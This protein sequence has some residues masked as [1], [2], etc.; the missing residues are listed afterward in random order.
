MGA[1]LGQFTSSH[2]DDYLDYYAL[3][4]STINLGIRHKVDIDLGYGHEHESRGEGL[5]EGLGNQLTDPI[6]YDR[7]TANGKYTYAPMMQ[8]GNS[9]WAQATKMLRIQTT[10]I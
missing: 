6:E 10:E 8:K 5:S 1:S 9:H 3:A 4:G 2:E 7:E